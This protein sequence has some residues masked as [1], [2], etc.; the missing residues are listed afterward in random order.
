MRKSAASDRGAQFAIVHC[1]RLEYCFNVPLD[2]FLLGEFRKAFFPG[3]SF[4]SKQ[5]PPVMTFGAV[6]STKD[7]K[8]ADYHLHFDWSLRKH[9]FVGWVRYVRGAVVPGEN[10]RPPFAESFMSWFGS[11]FKSDKAAAHVHAFFK[12]PSKGWRSVLPLPMKLSLGEPR[13]S[14]EVDGMSISLTSR[15]QG[16]SHLFLSI[17]GDATTLDLCAD[18][19]LRF[20]DFNVEIQLDRLSTVARDFVQEV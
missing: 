12:Y 10:E 15:V 16:V 4:S 3:K 1:E 7:A 17:R 13:A 11:F 14:V 19:V 8:A 6:C 20:K 5:G 9:A 18:P 2:K